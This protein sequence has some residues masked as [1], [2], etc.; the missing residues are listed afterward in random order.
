MF[1]PGSQGARSGFAFFFFFK[2]QCGWEPLGFG[3]MVGRRILTLYCLREGVALAPDLPA[4][5]VRPLAPPPRPASVPASLEAPRPSPGQ[6][7]VSRLRIQTQTLTHG[8]PHLPAPARPARSSVASA[9]SVARQRRDFLCHILGLRRPFRSDLRGASGRKG[10]GWSRGCGSPSQR[11]HLSAG[12][13]DPGW[14]DPVPSPGDPAAAAR[15]G[16]EGRRELLGGP[17]GRCFAGRYR[18]SAPV[19]ELVG[20]RPGVLIITTAQ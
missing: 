16:A 15:G 2:F 9:E 13:G 6:R 20:L 18:G 1:R 12:A 7:R 14:K 17:Q 5:R 19:L 8:G 4:S 11:W 3:E 10:I